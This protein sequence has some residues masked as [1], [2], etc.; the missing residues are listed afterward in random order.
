M[1]DVLG[2]S[3]KLEQRNTS[4]TSLSST[5]RREAGGD[6]PESL[7][8]QQRPSSA[9]DC[10]STIRRSR[11]VAISSSSTTSCA[12]AAGPRRSAAGQ[13][14]RAQ[15][16]RG[17]DPGSH[18]PSEV[19]ATIVDALRGIKAAA[20]ARAA[21]EALDAE[22]EVPQMPEVSD[23]NFDEYELMERSWA[24]TIPAGLEI[25]GATAGCDG[26]S[27]GGPARRGGPTEP[28]PPAGP[29]PSEAPRRRCAARRSPRLR[30]PSAGRRWH[31][32]SARSSC[33]LKPGSAASSSSRAAS[34]V[35]TICP[36]ARNALRAASTTP[37]SA[38]K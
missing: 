33:S 37:S 13:G 1:R 28:Q 15:P 16:C 36:P 25:R 5:P 23:T 24:G 29:P 38:P 9:R 19:L 34:T 8:T 17:R 7:L 22:W 21:R 4:S 3:L 10:S 14:D 31:A 30:E 6:E 35:K 27:R 20:D 18:E 2:R 12:A 26:V 32:R 11:S